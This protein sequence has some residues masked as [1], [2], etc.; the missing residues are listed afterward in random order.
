[1]IGDQFNVEVPIF[2]T[3]SFCMKEASGC[4]SKEDIQLGC[5]QGH[6]LFKSFINRHDILN[7][8]IFR[9]RIKIIPMG[10]YPRIMDSNNSV[11]EL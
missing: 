1:M 4:E 7:L 9:Y 6:I 8:L 10:S 5:N 2:P 11:Y 3:I